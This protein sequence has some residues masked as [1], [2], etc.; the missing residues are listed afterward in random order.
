MVAT[1]GGLFVASVCQCHKAERNGS[2]FVCESVNLLDPQDPE[3]H[4]L[5]EYSKK[6]ARALGVVF[7]PIHM[8][9][10]WGCDGPV[11][12]EAGARLPG[13]GLPSL[14]S[15]VYK[16]DLLS[17]AV[18]TYLDIAIPLHSSRESLGRVVCLVSEV[19]RE[20]SGLK[21]ADLK[22]LRMLESY[23][24]HKLYIQERGMLVRTID[25][26]T[27]PGVVFLAHNSIHRLNEDERRVRDILSP[28]LSIHSGQR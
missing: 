9:L 22:R 7:G 4:D 3:L 19:E 28:Y 16:P 15:R 24:A 17:A 20:F 26:A 21:N 13:A 6:A 27:C 11:M 1:S 23:W 10:I 14:Y 12:I 5:I 18:C 8:E 2:R 25:F